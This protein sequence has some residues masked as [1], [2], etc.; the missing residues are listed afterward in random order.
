MRLPPCIKDAS[1]RAPVK[2]VGRVSRPE[3][4]RL[5]LCQTRH[6][7]QRG[8]IGIPHCRKSEKYSRSRPI[9]LFFWL[10]K[11]VKSKKEGEAMGVDPLS[12]RRLARGK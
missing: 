3:L 10:A 9:G 1:D 6:P 2:R 5:I 4:S 7:A 12:G 11:C 8:P